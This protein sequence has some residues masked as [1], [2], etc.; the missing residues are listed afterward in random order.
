MTAAK[1][2][3]PTNINLDDELA[4]YSPKVAKP[5]KHLFESGWLEPEDIEAILMVGRINSRPCTLLG[6]C[7]VYS[8]IRV[9]WTVPVRDSIKMA[10]ALGRPFNITWSAQRIREEH[11][12]LSQ[13]TTL[14][15]MSAE[16]RVFDVDFVARHCAKKF[17][18]YW[19]LTSRR[20]GIEGFRQ[21][22]CVA[23]YCAEIEQKKCAIASL[24]INEK[25]W[26]VEVIPAKNPEEA[27]II[28]Q[29][30]SKNGERADKEIRK[31]VYDEMGLD[32][33]APPKRAGDD[34]LDTIARLNAQIHD[35]C[36]KAG[37]A[38]IDINFTGSQG[39]I[40]FKEPIFQCGLSQEELDDIR[41]PVEVPAVWGDQVGQGIT[42][43]GIWS[44]SAAVT[45][46]VRHIVSRSQTGWEE[47]EGNGSVF[48]HIE[49][50]TIEFNI[51]A[52]NVNRVDWGGFN[53]QTGEVL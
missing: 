43:R 3:E 1:L 12:R 48:F 51:Y 42:Q 6:Y 31:A 4:H 5:V 53:M 32:I 19:I 9:D 28:K 50:A 46:V 35:A 21:K 22:H 39:N 38:S 33:K 41:F 29:I 30:Q 49:S 20:L 37:I 44:L 45:Y 27:P 2:S 40:R 11:D 34:S 7:A 8:A 16:N 13:I 14:K 10:Y 18:G 47:E 15:M 26:T 24:F 36:H 52:V 23:R 17:S 25:R